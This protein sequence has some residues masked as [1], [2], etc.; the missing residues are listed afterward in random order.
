MGS[1]RTG[2]STNTGDTSIYSSQN[3]HFEHDTYYLGSNNT[4]FLWGTQNMTENQWMALGNDDTGTFV[5]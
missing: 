1:G 3:N 4:Y 5:R 2:M